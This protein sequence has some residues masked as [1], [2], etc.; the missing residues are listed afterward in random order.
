MDS[1]AWQQVNISFPDWNRSEQTALTHLAPILF[2]AEDDGAITSWFHIRKRPCWRL[3]YLPSA[4]SDPQNGRELDALTTAGHITGW[5][6]AVYEPEIHAFGGPE[7]M[8]TAHR[9]FHHDSRGL[10]THLR[11]EHHPVGGHR[12]EISLLL[13]TALMRTAGLD[14]YEQGDVWA[15]V[16]AHRLLPVGRRSTTRQRAAVHRLLTVDTD[17]QTSE[18]GPLART[19]EWARAYTTAGHKLSTLATTGAL[20]RGLREVLAHHVIFAWNRL[21]LPYATQAALAAT[22][23]EVVFG[24]DPTAHNDAAATSTDTGAPDPAQSAR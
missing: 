7:A 16:A 24:P 14:W 3:R 13:C 1:P 2:A 10:L 6:P 15:R 23:N 18:N 12:R 11:D 9:F 8:E 17:D 4:E 19:R 5:T 20:H 22:A 21:G